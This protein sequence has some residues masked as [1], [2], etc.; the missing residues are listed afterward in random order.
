MT[1]ARKGAQ[2]TRW[3]AEQVPIASLRLYV[4]VCMPVHAS[5]SV[6]VCVRM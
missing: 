6:C 2:G 3:A 1:A 4:C 5:L